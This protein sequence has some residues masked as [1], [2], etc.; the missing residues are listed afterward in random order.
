MIKQRSDLCDITVIITP[1]HL[2]VTVIPPFRG[3]T[4]ITPATRQAITRETQ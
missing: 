4:H 3:I 1:D 2:C